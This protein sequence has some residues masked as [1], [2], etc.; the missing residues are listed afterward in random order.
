MEEMIELLGDSFVG[1]WNYRLYKDTPGF[2]VTVCVKGQHF[3]TKSYITPEL[4]LESVISIFNE[5]GD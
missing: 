3:D 4:A 2:C 1:L 5:I